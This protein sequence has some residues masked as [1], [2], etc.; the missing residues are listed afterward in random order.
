MMFYYKLYGL[1][2]ASEIEF[3]EA[4]PCEEMEETDAVI[5]FAEPPEWVMEQYHEGKYSSLSMD[6]MWFRLEDEMLIYVEKGRDVRVKLLDDKMDRVRMRSYIL[7]GAMTFLM[8]Q[9]NYVLIHGSALVYQDKAFIVSGCSGSG[10]S[11]TALELLKRPDILFAS[12]DIC[13]VKIVEN[14]CLLYPG[15]PFQKVCE[16]VK[17][18][19]NEHEYIY[20]EEAGG[21]FGR[22]L[23]QGYVTKPLEITGMF[24]LEK[25]ETEQLK[26]TSY[27]GVE[28][29]HALT[30][31]MFR[32]ELWNILGITPQRLQQFMK[33][34]NSL[35]IYKVE[36]PVNSDTV[37]ERCDMIMAEIQK[38]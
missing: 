27:K 14:Q 9:H 25:S 32:G 18:R 8:M 37:N 34:A 21:K 24:I 4:I 28:A 13:A 12:D 1:T 29:L 16:D 11:T 23:Q 31:N 38:I 5:A 6:V 35:A 22:K 7:S 19:E 17:E 2:V 10:K 20:L 26:M 15:P 30:H 33:V 3:T 36:R